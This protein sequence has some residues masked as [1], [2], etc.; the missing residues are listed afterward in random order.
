M[1]W[2]RWVLSVMLSVSNPNGHDSRGKS[3]ESGLF[4]LMERH[5]VIRLTNCRSA[6]RFCF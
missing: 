1:E 6:L 2:I 4:W 5:P 3:R